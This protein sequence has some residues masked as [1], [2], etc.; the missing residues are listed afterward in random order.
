MHN[1][2]QVKSL[3][4]FLKSRG[5]NPWNSTHVNVQI[6]ERNTSKP[7]VIFDTIIREEANRHSLEST[8]TSHR[9]FLVTFLWCTQKNIGSSAVGNSTATAT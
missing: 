7:T 1:S 4:S 9:K 3:R 5:T 2:Y 8:A 6:N